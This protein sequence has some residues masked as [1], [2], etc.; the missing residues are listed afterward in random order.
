VLFFVRVVFPE[1]LDMNPYISAP[2]NKESLK[3]DDVVEKP[4]QVVEQMAVAEVASVDNAQPV[5]ATNGD[6]PA[7][8]PDQP[9][10][11]EVPAVVNG[12]N[13]EPAPVTEQPQQV[14]VA[15][16]IVNGGDNVEPALVTDQPQEV[17]VPV[18][19]GKDKVCFFN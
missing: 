5:V 8:K 7:P 14:E 12:A 19:N 17:E 6:E 13:T 10:D 1:I 9:Q 15:P 4:E 2:V 16:V 3:Q 18:V 11:S